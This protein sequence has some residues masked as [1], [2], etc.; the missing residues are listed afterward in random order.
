M[1]PAVLDSFY[2]RH[3]SAEAGFVFW[4]D[5]HAS[6]VW[7]M[8]LKCILVL[9]RIQ[10]SKTVVDHHSR[11]IATD[12]PCFAETQWKYKGGILQD[13]LFRQ[14]FK[15]I[16]LNKIITY[17]TYT[18]KIATKILIAVVHESKWPPTT[19]A[20]NTVILH[21]H[22][23]KLYIFSSYPQPFNTLLSELGRY[24]DKYTSHSSFLH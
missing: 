10:H 7:A 17:A 16:L 6:V 2:G 12:H 15:I 9:K 8:L 20:T 24:L 3:Q 18:T 23:E 14:F 4:V 1:R 21:S 11:K 22:L 19:I 13:L 5:S